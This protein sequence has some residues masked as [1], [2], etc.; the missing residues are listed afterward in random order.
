M[1]LDIAYRNTDISISIPHASAGEPETEAW[2][3][4]PS[5]IPFPV[6][7]WHREHSRNAPHKQR[8]RSNGSCHR[9]RMQEKMIL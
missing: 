1:V 7:G 2:Y 3:N 6:N 5:A 8:R 9:N 4:A